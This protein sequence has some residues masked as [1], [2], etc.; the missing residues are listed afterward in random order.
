[1]KRITLLLIILFILLAPFAFTGCGDTN[2]TQ[3]QKTQVQATSTANQTQS[4]Q[5]T[6]KTTASTTTAVP[7][8]ANILVQK[9]NLTVKYT[10]CK[11]ALEK[12]DVSC[13]ILF[14][15]GE[16]PSNPAP[17]IRVSAKNISASGDAIQVWGKDNDYNHFFLKLICQDKN[18]TQIG[19]TQFIEFN[20]IKQKITES[21]IVYLPASDEI[22]QFLLYLGYRNMP[23]AIGTYKESPETAGKLGVDFKLEN[24]LLNVNVINISGKEI[25]GE[26]AGTKSKWMLRVTFK[27][28]SGNIVPVTDYNGNKLD[29][30]EAE[31][32]GYQVLSSTTP[33]KISFMIADNIASYELYSY[34]K[35][36]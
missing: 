16:V 34:I 10:I 28:A 33:K 11:E 20:P 31:I 1:M 25:R 35:K 32:A 3:I 22:T 12:L 5:V 2:A 8:A 17:Q 30:Q 36:L 15:Y 29:F 24:G 19:D 21:Q 9:K 14:G 26:Q 13:D 7:L 23:N 18:G 27:D 6:N 4:N